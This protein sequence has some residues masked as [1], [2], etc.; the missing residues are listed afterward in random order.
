[1]EG[2]SLFQ[3]GEENHM[4]DLHSN[5]LLHL[6]VEHCTLWGGG[7]ENPVEAMNCSLGFSQVR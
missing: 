5:E 4:D 6:L 1:M 3:T 2:A 7:V